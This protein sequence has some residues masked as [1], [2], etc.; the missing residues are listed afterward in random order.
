MV[1][2]RAH[3]DTL[4]LDDIL[5]VHFLWKC[6][7]YVSGSSLEKNFEGSSS[8]KTWQRTAVG[9]VMGTSKLTFYSSKDLDICFML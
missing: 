4:L 5:E 6:V 8:G 9:W 7:M 2:G 1:I 3:F